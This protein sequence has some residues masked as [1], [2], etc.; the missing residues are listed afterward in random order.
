MTIS[1]FPFQQEDVDHLRDQRNVLIAN[2]MGRPTVL[3]KRTKQ[4]LVTSCCVCVLVVGE[5]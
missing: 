3:G 1:L 2:E 5:R 4:S